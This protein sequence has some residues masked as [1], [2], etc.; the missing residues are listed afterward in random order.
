VLTGNEFF[1]QL[2]STPFHDGL[3]VVFIAAAIMSV[4]GAVISLFGGAKYVHSDEPKNVAVLEAS[5][6]RT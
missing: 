3:V 4:V 2:I 5:G 1:P 6:S